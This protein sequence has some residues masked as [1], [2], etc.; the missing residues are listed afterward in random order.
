MRLATYT[1][2]A[3]FLSVAQPLLEGE[4]AAHGL[5]LACSNIR[6]ASQPNPIWRLSPAGMNPLP[7]P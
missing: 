2:T 5:M 6:E 7:P 1:D 4:E 3:S